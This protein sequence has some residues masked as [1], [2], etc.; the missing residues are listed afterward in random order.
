M[1]RSKSNTSHREFLGGILQTCESEVEDL[2]ML[3]AVFI[4]HNKDVFG[5]E[6]PVEYFV[7]MRLTKC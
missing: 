3:D 4:F 5:L 2:G 1:W 6:I 7:F